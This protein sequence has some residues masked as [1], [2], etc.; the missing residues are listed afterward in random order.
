MKTTGVVVDISRVVES[1]T[2]GVENV[3]GVFGVVSSVLD[4][5]EME[6]GVVDGSTVTAPEVVDGSSVIR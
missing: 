5:V 2:T 3:T 4:V 6:I 1:E